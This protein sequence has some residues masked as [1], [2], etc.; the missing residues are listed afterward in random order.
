MRSLKERWGLGTLGL[1]WTGSRHT[2]DFR[3]L[4]KMYFVPNFSASSKSS[5]HF[6]CPPFGLC[7]QSKSAIWSPQLKSFLLSYAICSKRVRRAA[8]LL[9]EGL[10]WLLQHPESIRW[11]QVVGFPGFPRTLS[12]P[13]QSLFPVRLSVQPCLRS[14]PFLTIGQLVGKTEPTLVCAG[15]PSTQPWA[16]FGFLRV[17][18]E[19]LIPGSDLD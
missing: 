10:R 1:S 5:D 16:I 6:V 11:D 12:P 19:D 18:S 17:S 7:W 14:Q 4:L 2:Q 13:R 3:P 15:L 9:H 8:F